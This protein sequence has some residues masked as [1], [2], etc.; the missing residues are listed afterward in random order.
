MPGS[1]SA[2]TYD[3]IYAEVR[4]I[5]RGRVATYGQIARLAGYPSQA[6]MVG[7][8][9]N[10]LSGDDSVPWQRVI[11]ARG[12]ISRRGD[13]EWE[14]WQRTLLEE[15]GIAFSASGRVDLNTFRWKPADDS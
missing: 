13:R 4:R 3:S 9:L 15:E 8:A 12:E 5:P 1:R 14:R 7:Y 2:A 10:A 6:R 11:N